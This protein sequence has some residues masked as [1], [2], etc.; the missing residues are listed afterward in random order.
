MLL[1]S[2]TTCRIDVC[3][4]GDE[5]VKAKVAALTGA[6][7]LSV[8]SRVELEGVYRDIAQASV[9]R[10]WLDAILA[11]LPVLAFDHTAADAYHKI[12]ESATWFSLGAII[13]ATA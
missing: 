2:R 12:F 1:P 13:S 6:H 7:L 4:D 3:R 10:L 11:A 8:V 5:V 9:R